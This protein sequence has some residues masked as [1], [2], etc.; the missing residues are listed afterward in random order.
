MIG[1]GCTSWSA[2]RLPGCLAV[3]I[4]LFAILSPASLRA[5]DGVPSLAA[6]APDAVGDSLV[7]P[8]AA[9]G[10]F[11]ATVGEKAYSVGGALHLTG[12]ASY[13][14]SSSSGLVELKVAELGNDSM[15]TTSNLIRLRMIVT[16][17]PIVGG[18]SFNYWI[19]AQDA[20]G[21]LPP[22]FAYFN[23]D[24]TVQLFSAPDGIYYVYFGAFELEGGC[25]SGDGY[26]LD[27][28]LGPFPNLVQFTGGNLSL[29]NG[30]TVV[31]IEYYYPPW[32][33]YFV[34]A[35]AAEI[36]ALD[37]GTFPGWQRTGLQFNVYPLAGAPASSSTVYRFFSTIF[38][39]KSA[40][41]YTANVVEYNALVNGVGWQLEGPVFATPMPAN[42]GSCPADSIPIYR[43]Y[44]NGMGGAPNH[45]FT[46]DLNERALMIAAGWI[47][48]GQGIG[49]G[50][51][52]PL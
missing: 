43:L 36:A 50:F 46:T 31:A 20:F 49:V 35:I 51:C 30:P 40:H 11:R 4:S 33:M 8:G 24:D 14:A 28:F 19:L 10:P 5:A 41:F 38:D 1:N 48:E 2:A 29:L 47:P 15:T 34:T 25:G 32:N 44:N 23:I 26:C 16:T 3:F 9:Q 52:S 37:N 6:S 21:P 27:W 12:P 22:Q 17:T 13:N 45:R 7:A 39:P 18:N 42:D